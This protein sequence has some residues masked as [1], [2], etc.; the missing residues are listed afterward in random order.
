MIKLLRWAGAVFAFPALSRYPLKP[1]G[2]R[3]AEKRHDLRRTARRLVDLGKPVCAIVPP[4]PSARYPPGVVGCAAIGGRLGHGAECGGGLA[5]HYPFPV[6]VTER[7]SRP[8]F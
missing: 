6:I 7:K 1:P 3:A 4:C 5:M 2:R 8:D